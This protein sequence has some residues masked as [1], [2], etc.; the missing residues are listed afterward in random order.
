M[1]HDHVGIP[2]FIQKKFSKNNQVYCYDYI[3][4]KEYYVSI[5][6]L[7]VEKNY[8]EKNV[9]IN[10][11]S[12]DIENR[13]APFF[14][15]YLKNDNSQNKLIMLL[16]NEKLVI[17]F[18][19]FMIYRSKKYLSKIN[20]ESIINNTITPLNHSELLRYLN[21]EKVKII[22]NNS[23]FRCFHI[24]NKTNEPFI[25]NSIG[26]AFFKTRTNEE[27]YYMPLNLTEGLFITNVS[28][29]IC[30][31]D[32]FIES[33]SNLIIESLNEKISIY[34]KNNGNG[35]IFGYDMKSVQKYVNLFENKK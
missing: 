24:I 16:E 27:V 5:D 9:E 35:F 31:V 6:R 26:F 14:D 4:K 28:D 30:N 17:E 8:Y 2:K 12:N 18:L 1:S 15:K 20:G 19:I 3:R 22:D 29:I 11:L 32:G 34:E 10:I 23:D 25:N 33:E 7:G 21:D 13:F